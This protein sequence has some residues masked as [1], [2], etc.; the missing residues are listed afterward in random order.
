MRSFKCLLVSPASIFDPADPFT[1]G[2]VFM[3]IGLAYGA[4]ALKK[5][6]VK[7]EVLDLFGESPKE[8]RRIGDYVRLGASDDELI[9]K[10]TILNP[11][12]II[13]YANQL[14]NHT[15]LIESVRTV[16]KHFPT[17]I[18]GIAENTQAVTAYLLKE[19]ESEFF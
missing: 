10:I 16:R 6:N 2:V 11:D 13:F 8:A 7:V 17:V 4:A 19:V 14:L 18:V 5:I 3:P 15:S 9:K 1:T 12:L